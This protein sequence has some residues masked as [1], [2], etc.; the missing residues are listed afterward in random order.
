MTIIFLSNGIN[1]TIYYVQS[2]VVNHVAGIV[3]NFLIDD[4]LLADEKITQDFLKLDITK[5]EQNYLA[6]KKK[7][8]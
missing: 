6:L 5:S 1:M 2:Q 4:Y 7:P 3:D 8:S